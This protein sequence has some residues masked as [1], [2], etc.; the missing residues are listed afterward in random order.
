MQK[1]HLNPSV[2]RKKIMRNSI[3]LAIA[4]ATGSSIAGPML[5]EVLVT[6]QKSSQST[7]DIPIAVT[8][9]TDTQLDKYGF[10]NA[11]DIAA[12]VPNMQ[13]SG[14]YGDIQPIF[15]IRGVSMSD[16]SSNQASPIGVYV[17]ETYLAPVYSHGA[18]FFDIERLEVLRG[19]QGTLYGKNTTGGAINIITRT[20]QFDDEPSNYVKLGK[21]SYNASSVEAG[22]ENELVK[23]ILAGRAAISFKKDDGYMNIIGR[24]ENGGQTDFKGGRIALHFAPSD[25]WDAVFKYTISAND[26]LSTVARN[27]PRTDL[28]G[29]GQEGNSNGFIDYTG[30]SRPTRNLNFND[31]EANE[32]GPLV[33]NTN[34]TGLTVTFSGN[35]YSITSVSSYYD[36]DYDQMADTDGSPDNML[37]IHWSSDTIGYSQDLR[38]ASEFDGIF[39]IIAGAYYGYEDQYMN[40]RYKVFETPPDQRVGFAK[41]DTAEQYPFLLD[42]GILD[43]R[44]ES[45]KTSHAVYTQMRFDFSAQFGMD[46]GLRYTKDDNRL[47]YLNISRLGYDG[48]PRGSYVPGNTTGTDEAYQSGPLTPTELFDLVNDPTAL[49]DFQNAGYTHGPYTLDSAPQLEANEAEWTGKIGADYRIND[50]IMVYASASRGYRS[51]SFN[52]GAYYEPR[53][54]ETAYARPE[55]IEALELGVKADLLDNSMRI[56]GAVFSY[57]YTDQQ[58]INL[59][60]FSNF[61]ENAGG[62]TIQGFETELWYRITE[63][64]TLQIGLGYLET[65]YT[66]LTLANTE[67]IGDADDRVDLSG[68]ELILAPKL[69]YSVSVDYDIVTTDT[70]YL[71]IN[72]NTNFQDDQWFSAYNEKNGYGEVGQEAYYVVNGRLSWHAADD[73]FSVSIWGKNLAD[74]EYDVYGINLQAGFGHDSYLGGQ[75]RTYGAEATFRF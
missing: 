26:A 35:N 67:T 62:S 33:T 7:Q 14:P 60:G 74:K 58:F 69:N 43:Q 45:E 1:S 50:D 56:N 39:N 71:T 36:A 11:S 22:V 28:R 30:Y 24:S 17:D 66:E 34:I 40:N 51:G 53:P 21:G 6:A 42:F 63:K 68:N 19:P 44:L 23:D 48:S 3:C 4:T 75:P 65:E 29:T 57:D 61:L 72:G 54:L 5:E 9:M 38:F 37:T 55:Y 8:G 12:Q 18:N 70:G 20:P 10:E 47:T 27:E 52:G 16:Y 46:L 13:V 49:Q 31:T 73:S 32:V 59:V 41:P 15:S 25:I 2:F 64:L